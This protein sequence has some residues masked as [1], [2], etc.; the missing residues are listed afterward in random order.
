MGV[1]CANLV[2]AENTNDDH[3]DITTWLWLCCVLH[4]AWLFVTRIPDDTDVEVVV[5]GLHHAVCS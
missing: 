2:I 3:E 4:H 5:C 1:Y